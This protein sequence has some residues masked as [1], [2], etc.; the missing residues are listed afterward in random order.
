VPPDRRFEAASELRRR[1]A[2]AFAA[3]SIRTGSWDPEAS[4]GS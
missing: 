3:E 1:L 4:S 2:E